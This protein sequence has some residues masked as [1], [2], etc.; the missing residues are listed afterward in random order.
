[1]AEREY[2][3]QDAHEASLVRQVTRLQQDLATERAAREAAEQM[4]DEM[5]VNCISMMDDAALAFSDRDSA[6][7]ERDAL[8]TQNVGLVAALG[9][10]RSVLELIA[11]GPHTARCAFSTRAC[12]CACSL[13][14]GELE[15]LPQ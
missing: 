4:Q 3:V 1:M 11:H 9:Q 2:D 5:R 12:D 14:T 7:R 15:R 6:L 13:A 10:A 8:R